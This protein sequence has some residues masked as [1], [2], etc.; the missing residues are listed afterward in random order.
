MK[1][2][3]KESVKLK[4]EHQSLIDLEIKHKEANTEIKR[5]MAMVTEMNALKVGAKNA[6]EERK[7]MEIQNKKMRKFMRQ[8]VITTNTLNVVGG[9]I[10]SPSNLAHKSADMAAVVH[11]ATK[12]ALHSNTSSSSHAASVDG[13]D[14]GHHHSSSSSQHS[15]STSVEQPPSGRNSSNSS[16][17]AADDND[18]NSSNGG[19][20][21]G[22]LSPKNMKMQLN[23]MFARRAPNSHQ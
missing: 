20:E 8:S 11:A 21:P 15:A 9:M 16:A 4:Q 5:L 22:V 19:S 3:E 6:E 7:T 2:L 1:E 10:N 14:S 12:A 13:G 18:E 23:D 17:V